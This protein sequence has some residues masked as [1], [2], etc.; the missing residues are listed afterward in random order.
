MISSKEENGFY[1]F[2]GQ[3]E[4]VKFNFDAYSLSQSY[5]DEVVK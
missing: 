2:D 3:P 1:F 5:D 4:N